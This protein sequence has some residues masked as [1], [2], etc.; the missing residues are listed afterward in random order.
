MLVVRIGAGGAA[1]GWA[2]L[3]RGD[4][5]RLRRAQGARGTGT[6]HGHAGAEH[7]YALPE[8]DVYD[9]QAVGRD[10]EQIFAMFHRQIPANTR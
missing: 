3:T 9:S 2:G 4:A 1:G 7:G 5:T 10:W 8:R 6:G